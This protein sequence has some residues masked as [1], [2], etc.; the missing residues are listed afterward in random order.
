MALGGLTGVHDPQKLIDLAELADRLGFDTIS[1]GN[2]IA[3]LT[4]LGEKGII[5]ARQGGVIM[6]ALGN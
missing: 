6:R 3:F 1:L 5:K 2:T 4:Y